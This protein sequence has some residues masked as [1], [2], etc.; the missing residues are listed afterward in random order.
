MKTKLFKLILVTLI[1]SNVYGQSVSVSP[2]RLYY[3]VSVGEYKSQIV[4][5]TNNS[6]KKQSFILSFADF[7]AKGIKGKT[8]IMKQGESEHSCSKWLS[9]TPSFFEIEAGETQDV[10][11]LLQLPNTPDANKVRWATMNIKL[12]KER[13]APGKN[14]DKTVGLGILQT[15]QFVIHIF[16]T[17]PTVTHKEAKIISFK[18]IKTANDS[19]RT[20]QIHVENTGQAIVDCASYIELTN[21]NTGETIREKPIAFTI[22]PG[23][24]RLAYFVLPKKLK[25][26]KYSILAVV[27]YGSDDTIQAAE[28]NLV[29]K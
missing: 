17:P 12:A 21:L 22:L 14:D 1:A 26:G 3:T 4:K 20:L 24:E 9:A 28:M 8:A 27:D 23:S 29:V 11:V 16:Q 13:K 6:D 18:E 2:S 10:Q 15:F 19:I 5:V 25:K 7:E